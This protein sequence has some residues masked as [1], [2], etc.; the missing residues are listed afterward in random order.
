[1]ELTQLL[2]LI[3]SRLAGDGTPSRSAFGLLHAATIDRDGAPAVRTVV[4]REVS[5]AEH[6]I[7]FYSDNRSPK[8][9]TLQRS[10]RVALVGYDAEK[11]T[12]LRMVG[13][14]TL[15]PDAARRRAWDALSEHALIVYQGRVPPGTSIAQ[16]CDAVPDDA[17]D[18]TLSRERGY[19]HFCVVD[20]TVDRL[21]WLDL[22]DRSLHTR[23]RFERDG[24]EWR[25][26]WIAP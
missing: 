8:I 9:L 5:A 19:A 7:R 3:W 18:G 20:I 23:A 16:P 24:T 14:A 6:R 15:A 25:G 26:N 17:L 4:L 22:S 10:P 2:P 12:Q 11:R 1:M 13:D 21:D